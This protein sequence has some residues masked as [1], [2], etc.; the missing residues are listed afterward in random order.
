MPQFDEIR[1]RIPALRDVSDDDLIEF[2]ERRDVDWFHHQEELLRIKVAACLAATPFVILVGCAFS[3]ALHVWQPDA[4]FANVLT[5]VLGAAVSQIGI[6]AVTLKKTPP[7][8][9][10]E[11]PREP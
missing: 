8:S 3:S 11:K 7:A 9:S 4:W 6:S 1:D 10:T 5:A 2:E